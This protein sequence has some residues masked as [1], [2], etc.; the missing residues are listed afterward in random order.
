MN[1]YTSIVEKH[2]EGPGAVLI[3]LR[4]LG[5]TTEVMLFPAGRDGAPLP[6]AAARSDVSQRGLVEELIQES[7]IGT[8][9]RLYGSSLAF[10]GEH[11]P[12]GVF[13]AFV[14]AG[15]SDV[16]SEGAW[17]DLREA[18]RGLAPAWSSTLSTVR[19]RFVAR[20]PDD[21]LRIC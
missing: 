14:G 19:Q 20:A 21:A 4:R 3:L 9:D 15:A 16:S 5:T 1:S 18:C 17:M 11:G 12:L 13:V 10:P 7:G 6:C 2:S 8:V